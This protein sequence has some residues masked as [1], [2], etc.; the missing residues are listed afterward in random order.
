MKKTTISLFWWILFE[1]LFAYVRNSIFYFNSDFWDYSKQ[2]KISVLYISTFNN[3]YQD[4]LHHC[5]LLFSKSLLSRAV[6]LLAMD[7]V[8]C[9]SCT[10]Y[11]YCSRQSHQKH[12]KRR[13]SWSS[14]Q[15][16]LLLL[17]SLKLQTLYI[18]IKR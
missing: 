2:N 13:C 17:T 12:W 8:H 16:Y 5:R 14:I 4:N 11:F 1:I 3:T 10:H 7:L 15:W 6:L 18:I 9:L